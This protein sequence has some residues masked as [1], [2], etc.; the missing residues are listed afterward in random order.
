MV[1]NS[2]ITDIKNQIKMAEDYL[3]NLYIDLRKNQHRL[4]TT[5]HAEET[6]LRWTLKSNP[7]TYRVAIVKKDSVLQVKSVN[8]GVPDSDNT[9]AF[10]S[11]DDWRNSL[12]DDNSGRICITTP[13]LT[14][15]LTALSTTPLLATTDALKLKELEM[16]FPDV[17]FILTNGQVRNMSINS[18]SDFSMMDNC[19]DKLFANFA[20]MGVVGKPELMVFYEGHNIFLDDLL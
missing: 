18:Y 17:E 10:A 12:P 16:R 11:E 8:D 5:T 1:S 20:D 9:L 7:N 3:K 19:T 14:N 13:K 6:K 4:I 2:T 15:N